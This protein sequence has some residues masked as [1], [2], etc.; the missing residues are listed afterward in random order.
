MKARWPKAK[1]LCDLGHELISANHTEQ[2]DIQIRINSL[3]NGWKQLRELAEK[4]KVALEDASEACQVCF[5]YL[6]LTIIS[7]FFEP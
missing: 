7:F 1:R 4:R 5:F 6:Y 3:E 2:K